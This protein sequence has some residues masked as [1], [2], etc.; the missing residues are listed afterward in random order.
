M[1]KAGLSLRLSSVFSG[2]RRVANQDPFRLIAAG[3]LLIMALN[4]VSVIA[5][6]SITIDETL[7]IP[8]GYYYLNSR[9]FYLEPDHPPLSKI[10]AGLPLVF[11]P[12]ETPEL[13]DLNREPSADQNFIISLFSVILKICR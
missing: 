10:L 13:A 9:T 5:R 2:I 11:L 4:L 12:L 6:K 7:I 8:S 1:Q 3:L